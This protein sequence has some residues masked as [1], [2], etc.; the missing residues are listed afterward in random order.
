MRDSTTTAESKSGAVI[1]ITGLPSAGKSQF[2]SA[3][4][5]SL[6]QRGKQVEWL[7]GD[8]VRQKINNFGFTT[9]A[10]DLHLKYIA[11]TAS[12]LERHGV[13]T[14]CS[15]VSPRKQNREFARKLST[16]FVEIFMATPLEVCRERDA[17]GHYKK[18]LNGELKGF[19]GVGDSYETPES[20]E[21]VL[22]STTQTTAEQVVI[23]EKYLSEQ[24]GIL[25]ERG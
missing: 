21:L 16:H 19:T 4:A 5:Q 11:H 10:R 8:I 20:P 15:F 25:H 18:A 22:D 7:D 17:K 3:L 9:E 24:P 12:L 23:V 6:E 2:A 1:W 13:I 14:I